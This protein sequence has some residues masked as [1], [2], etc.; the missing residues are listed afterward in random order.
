MQSYL[1]YISSLPDK[2]DPEV[3]G[4]HENAN[5]AFQ[6]QESENM[7]SSILSMQPRIAGA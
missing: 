1:D 6:Q 2:D 4:M 5:I 7:L 3:F